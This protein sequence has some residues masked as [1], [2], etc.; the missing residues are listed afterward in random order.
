MRNVCRELDSNY[1]VPNVWKQ[2]LHVA[3]VVQSRRDMDFAEIRKVVYRGFSKL[4]PDG[5]RPICPICN[6]PVSIWEYQSH[7]WMV[8]RG[9]TVPR[10]KRH[11]IFVIE[12]LVPTHAHC[13]MGANTANDTLKCLDYATRLIP[14]EQIAQWYISLW[15]EHDIAV[16]RG[17]IPYDDAYQYLHNLIGEK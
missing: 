7:E 8:K 4:S 1:Y 6:K 13:N 11:L 16:P 3:N 9:L 5:I 15:Q 2:D 10:S 14:P 17:I 12:N